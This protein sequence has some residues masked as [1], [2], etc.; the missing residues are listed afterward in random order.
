M[1]QLLFKISFVLICLSSCPYVFS[2]LNILG[3][4]R[5]GSNPNQIQIWFKPTLP[6]VSEYF[7]HL[8]I[9]IAIP[10]IATT[11]VPTLTVSS[12]SIATF[13]LANWKAGAQPVEILGANRVWAFDVLSTGTTA[14]VFTTNQEF[15]IATIDVTGGVDSSKV[16]L[17]DFTGNLPSGGASGNAL[18]FIS[19]NITG[20]S[21]GSISSNLF[22]APAGET[23]SFSA[24]S[25]LIQTAALITLPITVINFRA[26]RKSSNCGIQL[27]WQVPQEYN[28]K[29]CIVERNT[30]NDNLKFKFL[31]S[32]NLERNGSYNTLDSFPQIGSNFYRLKIIDN[33]SKISYSKIIE[34]YNSCSLSNS[35]SISPNPVMNIA[36]ISN[37]FVQGFLI[38]YDNQGKKISTYKNLNN[39]N[40]QINM[41]N[42]LPGVYNF[43][44]ITAQGQKTNIKVVKN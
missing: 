7:N 35:I 30:N 9:A 36:K 38:I 13:P 44:F 2:Q 39:L 33:D 21:S 31:A 43:Q 22:Y 41:S 1:K 25:T 6:N 37:L 23:I 18:F 42:F 5:K 34:V 19:L 11:Q 32:I 24:T 26:E 12:S 40:Q 4:I 14:T 29:N 3:T 28:L 27:T 16:F 8:K 15:L 20:K 17:A 10:T